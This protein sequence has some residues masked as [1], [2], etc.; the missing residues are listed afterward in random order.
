MCVCYSQPLQGKPELMYTVVLVHKGVL[1]QN[2]QQLSLFFHFFL[3]FLMPLFFLSC[4]LF[5]P[6]ADCSKTFRVSLGSEPSPKK[7]A[8]LHPLFIPI[9]ALHTKTRR[10]QN[11]T[12][13][14]E[15]S[16]IKPSVLI[17]LSARRVSKHGSTNERDRIHARQWISVVPV[18]WLTVRR[19]YFCM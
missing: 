8:H 4:I 7:G 2:V 18:S 9:G 6:S 16:W 11:P 5:S 12:P 3:F 1:S 15:L 19:C 10:E 14:L 13:T 17:W